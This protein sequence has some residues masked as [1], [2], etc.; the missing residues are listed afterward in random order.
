MVFSL[1]SS[2]ETGN[3]IKAQ[4]RGL[5]KNPGV[6]ELEAQSVQG[7]YEYTD[8]EGNLVSLTYTADENGFQAVGSHLPTPPP[9]PEEILQALEKLAAEDA[10]QNNGVIS[11]AFRYLHIYSLFR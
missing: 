6:P 7:G 3:G 4:E 9:I 8:P 11:P 10:A 2:Y 5:L 1:I